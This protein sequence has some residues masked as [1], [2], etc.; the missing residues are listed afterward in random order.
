MRQSDTILNRMRAYFG[1]TAHDF[2]GEWKGLSL[3]EQEAFKTMFRE[4]ESKS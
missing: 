4:W 3:T 2:L 1:M